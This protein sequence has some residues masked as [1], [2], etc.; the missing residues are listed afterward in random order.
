MSAQ[1]DPFAALDRLPRAPLALLPTPIQPL[2]R[3]SAPFGGPALYIKRDDKTGLA[4]GS[5]K[6][7][8][9]EFL[10]ALPRAGSGAD[11]VITAGSTQSN[12]ARQ[13]AAGA[14]ALGWTPIS[15]LYVPGGQPPAQVEGNL[16]LCHLLGATIH[17]TDERAPYAA[18]LARVEESL[19]AAG[20]RPTSSLWRL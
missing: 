1:P 5:N 14:A 7:R 4:T 12:H 16:L 9:L 11:C 18:T 19:R 20:R 6:T 8:K 15:S 2:P 13:T 3:L 17:W 10:L